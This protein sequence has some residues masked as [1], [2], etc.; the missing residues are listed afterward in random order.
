VPAGE[1][2]AER[3]FS[4]AKSISRPRRRSLG[5]CMLEKLTLLAKNAM[6]ERVFIFYLEWEW[7]WLGME[8]LALE[9]EELEWNWNGKKAPFGTGL[10]GRISFPS[11]YL[12]CTSKVTIL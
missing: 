1:A 6:K 7:E 11:T 8:I 10:I 3:L 2:A 5:V 4:C 9:N 12:H